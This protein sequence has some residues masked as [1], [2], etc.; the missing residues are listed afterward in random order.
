MKNVSITCFVIFL[1]GACGSE[2]EFN[3][4]QVPH[5]L[6]GTPDSTMSG[7]F[8]G[9]SEELTEVNKSKASHEDTVPNGWGS[10]PCD[11]CELPKVC[12]GSYFG[13][14]KCEDGSG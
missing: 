2:V 8:E 3:D 13:Q 11:N 5:T 10:C 7:A 6:D 9:T 4:F 14:C 12:R 1:L